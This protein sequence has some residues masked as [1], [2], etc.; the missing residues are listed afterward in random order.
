MLPLVPAGPESDDEA[1]AGGVVEDGRGLGEHRR[2]AERRR[3]H[4][5]T[6]PAAGDVVDQRGCGGE[7]LEARPV[8]IERDVGQVVVHPDRLEHVV[9]ADTRPHR[10]ECRPVDGLRGRLDPDRDMTGH[11]GTRAAARFA[12]M[13]G[14][15]VTAPVEADPTRAAYFAST[16]VV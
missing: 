5:M 4:G 8:P 1:P 16:P 2:V 10:I 12:V 11:A 7:C 3:E 15:V 6:D 9:G 13:R 14:P